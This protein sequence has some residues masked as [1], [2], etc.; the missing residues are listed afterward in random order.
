ME[1]FLFPNQRPVFSIRKSDFVEGHPGH[2]NVFSP[3]KDPRYAGIS[4]LP[5]PISKEK[6]VMPNYFATV[7]ESVALPLIQCTRILVLILAATVWLTLPTAGYTQEIQTTHGLTS[8]WSSYLGGDNKDIARGVGVDAQGNIYVAGDTNSDNWITGSLDTTRNGGR[9]AFVAKFSSAGAFLWA[10]Y[11]GGSGNE[12]TYDMAVSPTGNVYVVGGTLSANWVS[13]GYDT[14]YGGNDDGFVIKLNSDGQTVWST[15]LGGVDEDLAN[16]V[17]LDNAG[18]IYIAGETSSNGWISGGFDPSPNG[19]KDGFAVKLSDTGA[20]LWSTYL[21]GDEE[22]VALAIAVKNGDQVY[23]GGYTFSDGWVSKGFDTHHENGPTD[24]DGFLICL[25]D[26]G[27]HD[28]SS[29]LGGRETDVVTG[30]ALDSQNNPVVTGYTD[31]ESDPLEDDWMFGGFDTTFEGTRDTLVAKFANYGQLLWSTYLGG[32]KSDTGADLL[33]DSSDNIFLTGYTASS[34]WVGGGSQMENQG[35]S[36]GYLAKLTGSGRH[37]WS[38]FLGGSKDES[39][40]AIA[41]NGNGEIHVVGGTNSDDWIFGGNDTVLD[42]DQ[43]AFLTTFRDEGL[44]KNYKVTFKHCQ[45]T[46]DGYGNLTVS[47]TDTDS[48][49]KVSLLKK[50]P[51][52]ADPLYGQCFYLRDLRMLR[53][54]S[55]AGDLGNFY[56]NCD[57]WELNCTGSIGSLNTATANIET[58]E[59]AGIQKIRMAAQADSA[60]GQAA[61]CSLFIAKNSEDQVNLQYPLDAAFTGIMIENFTTWQPVRKMT[62]ASKA[63]VNSKKAKTYSLAGIGKRSRL[64]AQA[65]GIQTQS[66]EYDSIFLTGALNSLILTAAPLAPDFMMGGITKIAVTGGAFQTTA[67]LVPIRAGLAVRRLLSTTPIKSIEAKGKKTAMGMAGGFI[68]LPDT[69]NSTRIQTL[70]DM[71]TISATSGISAIFYAGFAGENPT[72]LGKIGK[73]LLGTGAPLKGVAYVNSTIPGI[74]TSQFAVITTAP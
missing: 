6:I 7:L 35:K 56:T 74:D 62:V 69:P 14:T 23:V 47:D 61:T 9:D 59:A 2:S 3:G 46:T 12:T 31:S 18:N 42:G 1:S 39:G 50:I 30:V 71:E 43:N 63:F 45:V 52:V 24:Q 48:W 60:A 65:A 41:L 11:L 25:T 27:A 40:R 58:L 36:D 38:T 53:R 26:T 37:L 13:N 15:Y 57:V 29:Y 73:I 49:V 5:D 22:D 70:S 66:A 20:H 19:N 67:Q 34:E 54:V 33:V 32:N 28:W 17:A 55:V 68:G 64:V 21:G 4:A 44:Q 8:A 16:S 51:P 72:C 10:T